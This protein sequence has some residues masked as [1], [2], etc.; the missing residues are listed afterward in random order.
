[1]KMGLRVCLTV[2]FLL[3]IVSCN[4]GVEELEERQKSTEQKLQETKQMQQ[5]AEQIVERKRRIGQPGS[6]VAP[7]KQ[8]ALSGAV[9]VWGQQ[10]GTMGSAQGI[11]VQLY[12]KDTGRTYS[13]FVGSDNRF[14]VAVA[15]GQYALT[16]NQPG[17]ELYQQEITVDGRLNSQ[18]LRPIGLKNL[19]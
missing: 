15:P 13:A 11:I 12:N 5:K 4:G 16:I 1:M 14:N 2:I 8:V 10:P 19:K 6:P 18:L 17:Y 3:S 9:A 7:D